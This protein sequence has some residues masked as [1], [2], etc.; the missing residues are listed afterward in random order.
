MVIIVEHWI[1][2]YADTR[3]T[4]FGPQNTYETTV[5]GIDDGCGNPDQP[6]W[7]DVRSTME[8]LIWYSAQDGGHYREDF[9]GWW[10]V[11]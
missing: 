4:Y 6:W 10:W 9:T 11:L 8:S 5:P 7:K 2:Q 1:N 3:V